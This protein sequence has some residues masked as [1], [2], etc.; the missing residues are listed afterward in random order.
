MKEKKK[1]ANKR[2][3]ITN[4]GRKALPEPQPSS[5]LEQVKSALSHLDFGF[6]I[7]FANERGE[8]I[9]FYQGAVTQEDAR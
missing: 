6:T 2:Q 4:T 3:R 5:R 9:K 7:F 8:S 1:K